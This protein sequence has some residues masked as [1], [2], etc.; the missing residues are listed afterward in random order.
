MSINDIIKNPKAAR[1]WIERAKKTASDYYK[2][3]PDSLIPLFEDELRKMG[4]EFEISNQTLGFMPKN[5][6]TILP[7]AIK[8]YKLAKNQNKVD[9]QNHFLSFFHFK[10]MEEVMPMLI[11]DYYAEETQDLTRWFISDCIYQIRSRNYRSAGWG[12]GGHSGR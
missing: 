8:Y 12:T 4:F 7:I 11:E 1:E 5:K 9:E 2:K 3:H 6:K 10:G